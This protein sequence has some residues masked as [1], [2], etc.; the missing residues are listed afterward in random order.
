MKLKTL[1][2]LTTMLHKTRK[3]KEIVFFS[4]LLHIPNRNSVLLND[5]L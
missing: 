3:I 2:T 1:K 5:Y 4:I